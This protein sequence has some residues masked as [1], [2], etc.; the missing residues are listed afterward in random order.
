MRLG[1]NSSVL[2]WGNNLYTLLMCLLVLPLKLVGSQTQQSARK[3]MCSQPRTECRSHGASFPPLAPQQNKCSQLPAW[4][5]TTGGWP[6]LTSSLRQRS[7]LVSQA[8]P[9]SW[10]MFHIPLPGHPHLQRFSSCVFCHFVERWGRGSF[11]DQLSKNTPHFQ[12]SLGWEKA[13]SIGLS[14]EFFIGVLELE[15]DFRCTRRRREEK[16]EEGEQ[17]DVKRRSQASFLHHPLMTWIYQYKYIVSHI[18]G[19]H[20]GFKN[21]DCLYRCRTK[22]F[23]RKD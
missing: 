19:W 23:F 20:I 22:S 12:F 7:T 11:W 16:N 3:Q 14:M 15:L 6:R 18:R 2:Q 1:Y 4:S 8:S 13:G 9:P 5:A 17:K 10:G 21:L